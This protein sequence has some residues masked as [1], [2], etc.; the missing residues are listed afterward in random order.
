MLRDTHPRIEQKET[1]SRHEE[2][3]EVGMKSRLTSVRVFMP[4]ADP[5]GL[6]LPEPLGTAQ[7]VLQPA[8]AGG[9]GLEQEVLDPLLLLLCSRRSCWQSGA[10]PDLQNFQPRSFLLFLESSGVFRPAAA[11]LLLILH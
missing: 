7:S 11:F 2:E 9:A 10:G 6:Q 8:Q 1:H 4:S 3:Q 5:P